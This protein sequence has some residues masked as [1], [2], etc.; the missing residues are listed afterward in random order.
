MV[1]EAVLDSSIIIPL[2][3]LEVHSAWARHK[4]SEYR[5]F[6]ILDL[7]YYEVANA[8]RYKQ[9]DTVTLR[10]IEKAFKEA[11]DMMDLFAVHSYAEVSFD[12]LKLALEYNIALYDAAFIVLA[13]KTKLPLLT[14]DLKLVKKLEQTKYASSIETR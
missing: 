10:D 8:L 2:V 5:Y 3:T 6:H 12:A 9:S 14:L 1:T 11:S 13:E 4:I 7:S